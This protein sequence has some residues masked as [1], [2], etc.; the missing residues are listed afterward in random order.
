M[1][2]EQLY[3]RVLRRLNRR[4]ILRCT[5]DVNGGFELTVRNMTKLK[6]RAMRLRGVRNKP[7][8]VKRPM[9]RKLSA[10]FLA[11]VSANAGLS[12]VPAKGLGMIMAQ[13]K[14][15]Q[16]SARF[17]MRMSALLSVLTGLM[18]YFSL[19]Y[20]TLED[21]FTQGIYIVAYEHFQE[22]PDSQSFVLRPE[23]LRSLKRTLKNSVSE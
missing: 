11:V 15:S 9:W 1:E 8:G 22:H 13:D 21:A 18:A 17:S 23:E 20:K 4:A 6:K 16:D 19:K 3:E 7:D 2:M 12:D 5:E 10:I 14:K